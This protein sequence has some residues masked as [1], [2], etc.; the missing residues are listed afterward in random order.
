MQNHSDNWYNILVYQ[1]NTDHIYNLM[2]KGLSPNFNPQDPEGFVIIYPPNLP[3]HLQPLNLT[4]V[5]QN[6]K[7][8]EPRYAM[9]KNEY[10]KPYLA[11]G[12][13]LEIMQQLRYDY[14]FLNFP[15]PPKKQVQFS[16]EEDDED[17]TII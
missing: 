14:A 1:S 15:L 8:I 2:H 12:T 11:A 3:K 17:D 5:V 13:A 9:L 4:H 10:L 7:Y 6:P 16:E